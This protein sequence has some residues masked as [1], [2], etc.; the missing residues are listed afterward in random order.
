M[1]EVAIYLASGCTGCEMSMLDLAEGLLEMDIKVVWASP[2]LG[3]GKYSR[4]PEVDVAFVEGGIRL[5]EQESIVRELRRKSDVLVAFGICAACGGIP[6]LANLHSKDEIF[7]SIFK[8]GFTT[9]NPDSTIPQRTVVLD[10]KYELTLP[11]FYEN[12]MAV[13]QIV[14][15][16]CYIGGC[17]PSP[18]QVRN[19]INKILSG[20]KGWITSGRSV[21][22]F[23]QYTVTDRMEGVNRFLRMSSG[24]CFLKQKALC[25][26]PA[27][28]GD[29]EASCTRAGV[30]CRGCG[31]PLPNVRDYGAKIIDMLS[32]LL[33]E[34]GVEELSTGYHS[35]TK[36]IYLYSLPSATIPGKVRRYHV[37]EVE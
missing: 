37:R 24:E 11:D 35:L 34:R 7:E 20:K 23:C 12:V 17:P 2:T 29:C 30:P 22:D 27:T 32:T 31:G 10:G 3:D 18:E 6:G 33:D 26:G 14:S 1:A 5:D 13:D 4:I 19:A 25:F 21:C 28:Q 16:D 8:K 36:F 15:V 9:D